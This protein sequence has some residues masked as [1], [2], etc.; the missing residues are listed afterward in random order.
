MT[1]MPLSLKEVVQRKLKDRR[2]ASRL[3][4]HCSCFP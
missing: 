4:W 2:F 3:E 1:G